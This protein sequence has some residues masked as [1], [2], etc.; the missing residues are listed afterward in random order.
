MSAFTLVAELQNEF[1]TKTRRA[2]VTVTGPASYDTNGSAISCTD[3]PGGGFTKVHGIR[4]VGVSAHAN[5]KY[6][7]Q[8]VPAASYGT[9]PTLKVRD[10][11]AASDAEVSSTTDLSGVTLI[12]EVIGI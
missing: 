8:F 4:P 7:V 12:L 3:F 5:D 2:V 9:S 1:G 10:L 6:H 11:S